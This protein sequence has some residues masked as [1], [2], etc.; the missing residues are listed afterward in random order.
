MIRTAIN[1]FGR[2]GRAA[3]K[4]LTLTSD[5]PLLQRSTRL[6]KD[7]IEVVAI[8]DLTNPQTLAYLLKYDSVYGRF[9][10]D[11]QSDKD[12]L[13]VNGQKYPVFAIKEPSQL[14]WEKLNVDVV[15]ECTGRFTKYDQATAHIQAGAKRVIISAPGKGEGKTLVLGTEETDKFLTDSSSTLHPQHSNLVT[16]NA[17][18]TANSVSPVIQVLHS[19][20]GVEKALMSTVHGYT[21]TQSLVDAPDNKDR[22]RGRAAAVNIVPTSTGAAI[23]TTKTISALKNKF[24]GIA[25]RVPVVNGSISDITTVVSKETS[26]E[27]V[28]EVF[29]KAQNNPLFHGILLAS[30]EELV[31]TDIIGSPYSAI[32][33]LAFTRVIGN[34]V[35]VLAWYDNEWAYSN[36]L[37]ELA[38]QIGRQ[39]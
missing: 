31:S 10:E 12:H 29:K 36:R 17:S 1:G 25:L 27:E 19:K 21:A 18:C 38:I 39:L 8:N 26:A 16:S 11:I 7:A 22:R 28:N 2:I 13:I 6:K 35:K 9:S 4:A 20:F 32:V 3:F 34:L 23:A 24:D 30:E 5:T 14:P 15:L 33:D 37:V